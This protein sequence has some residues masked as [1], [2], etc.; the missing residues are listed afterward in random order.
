VYNFNLIPRNLYDTFINNNCFFSFN[1]VLDE[2][3]DSLLCNATWAKINN[4]TGNLNWYDL[5]RPV[6]PDTLLAAKEE[7][8]QA[9]INGMIQTYKRGYRIEDYTPW[10]KKVSLKSPLLGDYLSDYFNTKDVRE[11]F[12]I[13]PHIGVWESC[14]SKL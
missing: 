10:M 11:A 8:G 5:Y 3:G 9:E 1:D 12:N 13:P 4:L 7:Y 6:Y 14:S 2:S